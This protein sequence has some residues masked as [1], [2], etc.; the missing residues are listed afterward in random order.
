MMSCTKK[1]GLE[2]TLKSLLL[3]SRLMSEFLL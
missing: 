3:D 2:T 1:A